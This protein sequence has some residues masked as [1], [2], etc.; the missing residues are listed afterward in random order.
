MN[1][2]IEANMFQNSNPKPGLYESIRRDIPCSPRMCIG[3]KV[4]LKPMIISQKFHLPSF[5]LRRWPNTLGH[6]K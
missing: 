5:S 4:M 2:P 3:P 1:D 6:Q